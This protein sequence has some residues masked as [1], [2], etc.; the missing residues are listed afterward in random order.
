M[1]SVAEAQRLILDTTQVIGIE[2]VLLTS[3]LH[4]VLGED[5][6]AGLSHP[7]WDNSAMDG[8]AVRAQDLVGAS[9]STPVS[10]KVVQEI[11][12]G[13]VSEHHLGPGEAA[14]IMTGA[15]IPPGADAVV[16]VEQTQSEGTTVKVMRE[17]DVGRNIRKQG[18]NVREGERV[19][20]RGTVLRAPEIGLLAL[21]GRSCIPVYRR[22]EVAI[23]ATGDELADLDERP[24]VGQIYNSNG[25][26]LW[27][28]V[29]E[30]GGE[31]RLLGIV[32][33]HKEMFRERL[34]MGLSSDVAL[35]SGAVSVGRYDFAR[36]VMAELGLKIHFW[37]VAMRP[38]HPL[39]FGTYD[40]K[41]IFGLPGNPVSTMI[42]F[43][44]FVRPAL[45]KMAGCQ[46][47]YP[48]VVDAVL[49]EGFKNRPGRTH[50]VRA[51][52]EYL[53]GE[54]RVRPAGPQG[55]GILMSMVKANCL[56]VLPP[57]REKMEVG[58]KVK[59]QLLGS[60]WG[61]RQDPGY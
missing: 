1:L 15:P 4:R 5:G 11:Q 13:R 25:Y 57:D 24:Q 17:M 20:T 31:P 48:P 60:R 7:P 38:G 22:P 3:A 34:K 26:A 41:L 8:Y 45:L 50:F 36:E 10:L 27:A 6:V 61:W 21:L 49:M 29:K 40:S 42:T 33:D 56:I 19:L 2:Q 39:V 58:E 12:A 52:V 32:R 53:D 54:Y 59:V 37:T 43:E 9:R 55:S 30:A 18:E 51:V 47:F 46:V 16:E 14:S 44:E 28:Q 23:L 35:I